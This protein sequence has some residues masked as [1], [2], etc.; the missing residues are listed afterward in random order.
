MTRQ[1]IDA[2][3]GLLLSISG[4]VIGWVLRGLWIGGV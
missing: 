2:W 3:W 4:F 1:E